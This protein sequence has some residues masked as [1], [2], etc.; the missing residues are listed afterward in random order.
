MIDYP[1]VPHRPGE[2]IPV[3]QGEVQISFDGQT[4][5]AHAETRAIFS[6]SPKLIAHVQ[7]ETGPVGGWENLALVVSTTNE[8]YGVFQTSVQMG[9]TDTDGWDFRAEYVLVEQE[10]RASRAELKSVL[11]GLFNFPDFWWK[12]GLNPGER[13]PITIDFG[14]WTLSIEDRVNAEVRTRSERERSYLL[15]TAAELSRKDCRAFA[16]A[17]WSEASEF[18]YTML[19]FL[20][21]KRAGPALAVGRDAAGQLT[22][23]DQVMPRVDRDRHPSHWFPRPFP[24]HI[25][26]LMSSAWILWQDQDKREAVQRAIEWYWEAVDQEITIETRLVLAQVGLELLSWVIMVED[27][28]RLS[29]DGFKKLTAADRMALLANQLQASPAIPAHFRE[30]AQ[31]AATA[32]NAWVNA[33]QALAEIR[34]KIIHPERRGRAAVAALDWQTKY[35]I[36]EWAIWLMELGILYLLGYKGRYDSRVAP[37]GHGFPFVPWIDP[38]Q[39]PAGGDAVA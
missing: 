31:T 22:W 29:A 25:P 2:A 18:L 1:F 33:P 21:A 30:L 4:V 20:A 38:S 28:A 35:Q 8:R 3:F 27:T 15:T 10:Y 36:T 26:E 17:H 7:A 13:R 34:N 11:F 32:P 19:G 16:P 5:P 24:T 23:R 9:W 39:A 37:D 14:D 12:N 6:P